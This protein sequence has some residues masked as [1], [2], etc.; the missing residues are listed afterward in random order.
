MMKQYLSLTLALCALGF[1]ACQSSFDENEPSAEVVKTPNQRFRFRVLT[2]NGSN[3]QINQDSDDAEDKVQDVIIA[4][5]KLF[6]YV[7][8]NTYIDFSSI[9]ATRSYRFLANLKPS[10]AERIKSDAAAESTE[11]NTAD[12]L[13]G[14]NGVDKNF[15]I[16]MVAQVDNAKESDF[17]QRTDAGTTEYDMQYKDV[18][19]FTRVFARVDFATFPLPDNITVQSVKVVNV[20]GKFSLV[21]PIVDYDLKNKADASKYPY[22]DYDLNSTP[23]ATR[24]IKATFY[25][26]EH[27]VSSPAFLT[28]DVHSMTCIAVQYTLDGVQ[29]E[30]R[31]RIADADAGKNGS[32][33]NGTYGKIV[34]NTVYRCWLDLTQLKSYPGAQYYWAN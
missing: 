31:I 4:G 29:R 18:V 34:R 16:P 27:V 7:A 21:T 5:E 28:P 23:D 24:R 6:T 12:Y 1:S 19:P 22:A 13:R 3:R 25:L 32:L 9:N 30:A 2:H 20:P 15:P 33:H 26:P 14:F 10:D 17:V 8:G 11:L